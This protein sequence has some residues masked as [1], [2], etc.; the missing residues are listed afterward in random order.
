M[1]MVTL[2]VIV[3]VITLNIHFRSP[4]THKMPKWVKQMFLVV[5]PKYLFMR[6]PLDDDESFRRLSNRR[7]HS[8]NKS[9]EISSPSSNNVHDKP[10][11]IKQDS[12]GKAYHSPRSYLKLPGHG[13][14]SSYKN[15]MEALY[16][17]PPVLKAFQNVC[18]IADLLKKKD[19]DDKV[20]GTD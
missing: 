14:D 2:S 7:F 6:R 10:L 18:F 13:R 15:K 17:S 9:K 1:V 12:S 8:Y 11:L 5:L 19:K 4:N 3:T 16:R 20:R